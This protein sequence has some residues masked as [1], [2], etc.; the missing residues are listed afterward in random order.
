MLPELQIPGLRL[1]AL[2]YSVEARPG[3]LDGYVHTLTAKVERDDGE[4]K[5]FSI[6]RADGGDDR[7]PALELAQLFHLIAYSMEHFSRELGR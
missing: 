3:L 6:D 1:L 7:L 5:T 2:E 4:V